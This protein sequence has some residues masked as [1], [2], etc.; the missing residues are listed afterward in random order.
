M[1]EQQLCEKPPLPW[2][3][4][5]QST[6]RLSGAAVLILVSSTPSSTTPCELDACVLHQRT[7]FQFSQASNLLRFVVMGPH[8]LTRRAMEPGHLLH[9]ALTRPSGANTRR[10][11][12][13]HPFVPAA[14]HLISFSDN[15]NIC[16][17]QWADHQWNVEWADNP[18]SLR[19][20]ISNTG[21]NP[22]M[23]LPRR[24]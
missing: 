18:T 10:P 2:S 1:L 11:K 17:V 20:F 4:R 14:Q 19:T 5:P 12:S 16:A 24:A 13:S 22:G 6:A 15:N 8:S 9:S 7:T 3:I 21:T 23:T